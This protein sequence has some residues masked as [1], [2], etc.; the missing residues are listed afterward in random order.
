M[1]VISGRDRRDVE[2]LV[3]IDNISH[4]GSHGF[5]ISGPS[6][7]HIESRQGS[8][9]L[10]VIERAEGE[11]RDRLEQ[12]EDALVGRRR[13]P[14]RWNPDNSQLRRHVNAA[15]AYNLWQYYQVTGDMQFLSFCGAQMLLEIARFWASIAT[16]N[17]DLD[18]YELLGVMGPD[19]YHDGYP[20]SDKP[21][22]D[23][24]A[25]PNIMATWILSRALDLFEIPAEVEGREVCER[26]GLAE[27]EPDRW[28]EISR[29]MRI[30]FHADGIIRQFEGY[31]RL[32]EFDWEGYR[33]KYGDMQRLDRIL[34]AEE[35]TPTA[36]RHP[37]RRM[38]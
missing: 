15:I 20:D 19:E 21:G 11:L 35:G 10:P 28:R 32:Q 7:Q 24:N 27:G 17:H 6:D 36:T 25:C 8:D 30:V 9:F 12:I 29:K 33:Q 16:Y 22:L 14:G 5:D 4:A 37:S 3:G 23:N 26:I 38:C 13:S 18:R 31:D 1:A 2:Q 34:E